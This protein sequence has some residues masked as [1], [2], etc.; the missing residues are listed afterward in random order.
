MTTK[1]LYN[2]NSA[3]TDQWFDKWMSKYYNDIKGDD[4]HVIVINE[5][6]DDEFEDDGD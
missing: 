3:Y 1:N 4:K 6:D 2:S 5:I